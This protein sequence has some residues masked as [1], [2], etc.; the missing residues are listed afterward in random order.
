MLSKNTRRQ[1]AV[2]KE[3]TAVRPEADSFPVSLR[4]CYIPLHPQS[5]V[6]DT[7]W[8]DALRAVTPYVTDQNRCTQTY[9]VFCFRFYS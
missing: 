4:Q 6:S 7:M 5:L 3:G 8:A 1:H 9:G 2:T